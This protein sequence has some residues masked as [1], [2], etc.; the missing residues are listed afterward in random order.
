M[1]NV[2]CE[3][4]GGRLYFPVPASWHKLCAFVIVGLLALDSGCRSTDHNA[5]IFHAWGWEDAKDAKAHLDAY[6]HVLVARID[7]HHWEDRGPH[8]LTPHHFEATVVR[9]YKGDWRV[10]ERIAFVH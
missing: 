9:S 4:Q 3:G 6:K 7:E 8:R 5:T 1:R 2:S 10:S